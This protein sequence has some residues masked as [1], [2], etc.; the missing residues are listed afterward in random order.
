[1]RWLKSTTQKSW[2]FGEGTKQFIVPQN[3]TPD[4]RWLSMSEEDFAAI[5]K[6]PVVKGLIKTNAI[7]VLDKEP[8]EIKNSLPHLQVTNNELRA[9]NETLRAENETLKGRI[10]ELEEGATGIDLEA[11]I[12]KAVDATK[13][14]YEQKLK[15]LD[16]KATELIGEKDAEIE[17]LKKKLKKTD[18]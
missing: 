4:N 12:A 7:M 15:E 18:E 10:K 3:V 5:A 13:A 6:Q 2:V 14:E 17:K 11:E 16:D 9:E 8:A 1:M